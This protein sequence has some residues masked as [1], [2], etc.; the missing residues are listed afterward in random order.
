MSGRPGTL[1][2]SSPP[3]REGASRDRRAHPT[4]ASLDVVCAAEGRYVAECYQD[5]LPKADI[6]RSCI[7]IK[8]LDDVDLDVLRSLLAKARRLTPAPG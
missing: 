2:R 6:G 8:R 4:T 3:G 1:G 5:R 7:R